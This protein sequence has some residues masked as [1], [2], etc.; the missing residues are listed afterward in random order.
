MAKIHTIEWT[1]AILPNEITA[2]AMRVNWHGLAGEGLQKTL[3]GLDD[4]ERWEES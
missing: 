2:F 4:N 1:P 3:E